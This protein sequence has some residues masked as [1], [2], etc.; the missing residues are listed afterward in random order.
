MTLGLTLPGLLD[1]DAAARAVGVLRRY[2]EPLS[3]TDTGFTGG[4]WDTFDPSG[5]R[6]AG[7]R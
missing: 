3:G 1:P 5:T 6:E 4:S 7:G 2:F